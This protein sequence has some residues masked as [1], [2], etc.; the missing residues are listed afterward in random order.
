MQRFLILASFLLLAVVPQARAQM[1]QVLWID[2][3]QGPICAGPLGPGPCPIVAN[4]IATHGQGSVGPI[5][6]Q[7]PNTLPIPQG[8]GV[9]Q[10]GNIP[11]LSMSVSSDQVM[12]AIQCAQM[13]GQSTQVNVDA[14]LVC[15]HG[16]VVLNKD[17]AMLVSCAE[18]A[19]GNTFALA[20][21][22]G[23]GVI[24]SK[25]TP[26]QFKAVDCAARHSDDEDSFAG[27]LGGLVADQLNPQ[28]RALLDCASNN[29]LQSAEFAGCAGQAMLG[30]KIP[31]EANVAINCAVQSQGD[32]GQFGACAANSF[33]KLNLNPEQQMTVQCVATTGGQP[34][35]AAACTAGRLTVRELTKCIEHGIGGEGCFGDNNELVGRNGFVVRN[36]AALGGG[37]NSMVRNP[38]Q[39]LGGPNSV[40][41]NPH[42]LLGGPNS[43]PNQVLRNVPSPPPIQVGSVGGHRVC[44]P[45]C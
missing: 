41:N 30:N 23:R 16:A 36:L 12:G 9:P 32:Y 39:I 17:S 29:D 38:V 6:N 7:L 5:N 1:L 45:W 13:T 44:I 27:C 10:V 33:L 43:F 35:A 8:G 2:P 42:Q 14:F 15:T 28:Q 3:V 21:C 40:F 20:Q 4:Y 34:Y 18:Q 22:A 24:G 11:D 31:P 37:P 25:L 19:N 26:S